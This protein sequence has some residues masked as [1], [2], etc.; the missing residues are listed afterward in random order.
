MQIRIVLAT[1]ALLFAGGCVSTKGGNS[2]APCGK[3][4]GAY[5]VSNPR[6]EGTLISLADSLA[7]LQNRFNADKDKAR[8]IALVSPT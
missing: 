4:G 3:C 5:K 2:P 6:G 8:L 1:C 7:P